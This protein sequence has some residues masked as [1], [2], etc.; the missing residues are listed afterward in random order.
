MMR[1]GIV[2]QYLTFQRLN[3]EL[4]KRGMTEVAQKLCNLMSSIPHSTNL[5]NTYSKDNDDA[6][7]RRNSIIQKAQAFSDMLK[8]CNDPREIQQYKCSSENDVSSANRLI[9]DIE[10]R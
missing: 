3:A 8:N 1:R 10:R 9:E 4:K 6:R 5:P 2:P 7:A